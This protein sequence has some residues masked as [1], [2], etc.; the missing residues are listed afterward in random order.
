MLNEEEINRIREFAQS[1]DINARIEY[2]TINTGYDKSTV[3]RLIT[4]GRLN[5]AEIKTNLNYFLNELN[6]NVETAFLGRN[7]EGEFR[8]AFAQKENETND[9][10]I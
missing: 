9:R 1:L 10:N 3:P 5:G 4:S 6:S 7:T 2:V 8:F